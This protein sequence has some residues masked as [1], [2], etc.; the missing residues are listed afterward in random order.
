MKSG[1]RSAFT[2]QVRL[3]PDTTGTRPDK[4]LA[5]ALTNRWRP[6]CKKTRGF[7]LEAE[8]LASEPTRGFRLQAEDSTQ[9]KTR[10][11][12]DLSATTGSTRVARRP[13]T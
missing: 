6:P 11:H 7:G 3:K 10:P 12:S 2:N 4:G 5:S 1:G 13:G 9:A 8:E